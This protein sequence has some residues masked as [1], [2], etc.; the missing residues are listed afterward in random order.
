MGYN[1]RT[2]SLRFRTLWTATG[3]G[4]VVLVIY[5]SVAREPPDLGVGI[6]LDLGHVIAYCWLM[7]WF[8]QLQRSIATRLW[9]ATGLFAMGVA[10]EYV[11]GA[12][13]YR[14]FDYFDMLR[15]LLGLV[16]GFLLALTPLQNLLQMLEPRVSSK[17]PG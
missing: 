2:Y 17:Q 15:N 5:L 10:L 1:D 14:H 4:F 9:I 7:L 12:L 8:A 3:Y 13:G 16:F 6:D 11:Q